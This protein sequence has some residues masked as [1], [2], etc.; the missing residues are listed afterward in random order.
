MFRI[1]Q[2][3]LEWLTRFCKGVEVFGLLG[4]FKVL[5]LSNRRRKYHTKP[6]VRGVKLMG[7]HDFWFRGAIDSGVMTHFYEQNYFIDINGGEPIK[8]ILDAG[9]N[10]GDET[11][12]FYLFYPN[13]VILAI[14]AETK[15]YEVLYQNFKKTTNVKTIHGAL[16]WEPGLVQIGNKLGDLAESYSIQSTPDTA[17]SEVRAYSVPEL[18]EFMKWESIDILKIDIEGAEYELFRHS[19]FQWISKV[20]CLIFEVPDSDRPTTTQVIYKALGDIPFRTYICGE[21]LV[22][23]REDIPW[24]LR[25]VQGFSDAMLYETKK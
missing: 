21:N 15:N 23:I 4:A 12:R 14:E 22:L 9:A 19:T 24:Q 20:K 25:K 7:K 1:V 11:T 2:R 13:A 16:W 17:S 3:L 18:M 6:N 8:T 10:I 5:I